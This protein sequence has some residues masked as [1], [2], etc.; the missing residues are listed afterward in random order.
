VSAAALSALR[1]ESVLLW[2]PPGAAALRPQVRQALQE[3]AGTAGWVGAE[4]LR[5]A[6]TAV[7]PG[8][9]L[10]LEAVLVVPAQQ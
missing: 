2:L 5:W 1:L 3:H 10:R 6:I 9:A 8:R 4:P 7:D